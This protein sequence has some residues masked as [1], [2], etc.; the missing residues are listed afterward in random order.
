M[1]HVSLRNKKFNSAKPTEG[2]L[3][4]AQAREQEIRI[5]CV[6]A[7]FR[8]RPKTCGGFPWLVTSLQVFGCA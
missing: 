8:W 4:K 5:D 3:Q 7:D 2:Q 1:E 6:F